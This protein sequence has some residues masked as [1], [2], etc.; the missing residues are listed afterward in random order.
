MEYVRCNASVKGVPNMTA[1]SFC[2]WVNKYLLPNSTLEPGY[3]RKISVPTAR[4]WLHELGFQIITTRARIFIDGHERDDVV[5][6]RKTFLRRMVKIGFLHF[7]HCIPLA[8]DSVTV[9]NI[10]NHF[11][12]VRHYMYAYLEGLTP[13]TEPDK[14]VKKY[15]VAAKSH[16]KIG[17]NE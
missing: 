6:Q 14:T 5:E 9:E 17:M 8:C 3:P 10:K 4:R 13:G 15:K 16:R 12:K 1:I 7:N 11:R 2:E